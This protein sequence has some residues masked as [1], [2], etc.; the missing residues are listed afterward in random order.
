MHFTIAGFVSI[1]FMTAYMAQG[2][3]NLGYV[4]CQLWLCTDYLMSNASVL[5]LLLISFDRYFSVTRPLYYRPRRTARKALTMIFCTYV[6][7]V[8]LILISTLIKS[9][10]CS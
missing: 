3:W 2:Q 6:I 9:I 1:P 8:S 4:T 5:N 7:S 10:L